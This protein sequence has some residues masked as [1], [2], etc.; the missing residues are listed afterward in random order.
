M[1]VRLVHARLARVHHIFVGD[2]THGQPDS[3]KM[4]GDVLRSKTSEQLETIAKHLRPEEAEA[5]MAC[6][7]SAGVVIS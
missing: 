1:H 6:W 5:M 3:Y 2:G 7:E 4:L